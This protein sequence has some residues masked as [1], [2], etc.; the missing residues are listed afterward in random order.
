MKVGNKNGKENMEVNEGKDNWKAS[1]ET[2]EGRDKRSS[3][4]EEINARRIK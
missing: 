3:I 2:D 4:N 1:T